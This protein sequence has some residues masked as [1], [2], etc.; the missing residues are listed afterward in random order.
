MHRIVIVMGLPGSGKSYFAKK[1][2]EKFTAVYINSDTVRKD[3]GAMGRYS[4]EDKLL[5][6]KE[7]AKLTEQQV[8]ENE[9]IIVDATF[10]L[11]TMRDIFIGLADKKEAQ[12]IFIYIIADEALIKSRLEKSRIDSEA[13]F[14][15]YEKVK[16]QFEKI[17]IP[18]Q[19]IESTENNIDSMISIA[20]EYIVH[21]RNRG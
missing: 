8:H 18:H 19:E 2:A 4:F 20:K 10:Y 12:I 14:A 17:N 5:V 13:D 9:T 6:Y 11:K 7:M 21:G 15:V 3:L 1:L 16:N